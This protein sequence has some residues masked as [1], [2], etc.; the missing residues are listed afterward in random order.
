MVNMSTV[1]LNKEQNGYVV[2]VITD[3]NENDPCCVYFSN[4]RE[5]EKYYILIKRNI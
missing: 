5:A 3:A 4:K 2:R 1:T